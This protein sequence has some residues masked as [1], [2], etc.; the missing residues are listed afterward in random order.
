MAVSTLQKKD[1]VMK[2]VQ[3]TIPSG[4]NHVQ[5]SAVPDSGYEFI[6]WVGCTTQ[7][8]VSYVMIEFLDAQTTTAWNINF[9]SVEA[10][11]ALRA[12]FLEKKI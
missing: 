10:D 7:S 1:V 12:Y 3:A 2:W 6:G 4:D 5:I 8:W 9:T 11:S